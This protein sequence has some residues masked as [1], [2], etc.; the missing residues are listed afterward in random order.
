[1]NDESG[2]TKGAVLVVSGPGGRLAAQVATRL[3]RDGYPVG[4]IGPEGAETTA[5]DV[6][7]AGGRALGVRAEPGDRAGLD[8]ALARCTDLGATAAVVLDFHPPDATRSRQLVTLADDEWDSWCE[9]PIRWCL[10]GLQSAF[11]LLSASGG[12]I[13]LIVPTVSLIGA[14]G[15]VAATTAGEAQRILAKSG[16]RRWGGSGIT[17]NV[18]AVPLDALPDEDPG[19][20]GESAQLSLGPPALAPPDPAIGIASVVTSLTGPL[21]GMVTG[22]TI[23]LDGGAVMA[24]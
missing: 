16:A 24:P 6:V 8:D 19:E 22:A 3:A 21:G 5:A 12:V 15:Y 18:V 7:S 11:Q 2:A 10:V 1:M 13:V 14:E 9:A 23:C 20:P 17:V 4:I